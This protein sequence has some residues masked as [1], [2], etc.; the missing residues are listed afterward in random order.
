MQEGLH[1]MNLSLKLNTSISKI[2]PIEGRVYKGECYGNGSLLAAVVQFYTL[3]KDERYSITGPLLKT[4]QT[5]VKNC[6]TAIP[7]MS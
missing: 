3:R 5:T 4:Y 7:S 1:K 6:F 2:M